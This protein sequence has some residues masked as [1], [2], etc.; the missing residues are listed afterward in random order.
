MSAEAR[1]TGHGEGECS[2]MGGLG[3]AYLRLAE[4]EKAIASYE[5]QLVFAR[6]I[7]DRRNEGISLANLGMANS[8][9]RSRER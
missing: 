2:A 5:Q 6:D 1:E 4:M 8:D 7:G 9:H 3:N